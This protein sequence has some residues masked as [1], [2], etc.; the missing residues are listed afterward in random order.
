[1]LAVQGIYEAGRVTLKNAVP[2]KR[3]N[4]LVIFPVESSSSNKEVTRAE[5]FNRLKKYRRGG[6]NDIDYEAERDEYLHEK[7]GRVT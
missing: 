3:T 1:M 5:A 2:M 4:V 7:Y 6:N